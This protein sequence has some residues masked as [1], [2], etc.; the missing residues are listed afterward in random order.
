MSPGLCSHGGLGASFGDPSLMDQRELLGACFFLA[1]RVVNAIK[2][3]VLR[4]FRSSRCVAQ[5]D[6]DETVEGVRSSRLGGLCAQD[7]SLQRVC[8]SRLGTAGDSED[9]GDH[10]VGEVFDAHATA[11]ESVRIIGL[12]ELSLSNSVNS[13]LGLSTSASARVSRVARA[14]APAS[15]SLG[16][17]SSAVSAAVVHACAITLHGAHNFVACSFFPTGRRCAWAEVH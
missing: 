1:S 17:S 3:M 13:C 9:S 15:V 11:S 7:A 16:S 12:P 4:V 5:C 6:Q 2:K 8:G 14:V 10:S